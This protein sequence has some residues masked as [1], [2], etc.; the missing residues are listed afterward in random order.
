MYTAY[1]ENPE[2]Q[3]LLTDLTNI[4]E[5]FMNLAPEDFQSVIEENIRRIKKCQW[6]EEKEKM[7]DL[8]K[9]ADEDD[10]EA[11]KIQMQ[12]RDRINNKM[13]LEKIND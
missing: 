6:E 8:Y 7:R 11:L 12:L 2:I 3:R 4:A 13:K 9:N 10:T 5:T 1:I